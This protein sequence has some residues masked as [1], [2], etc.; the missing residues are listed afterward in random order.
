VAV[1]VSVLA[2]GLASAQEKM[3]AQ[4]DF[5]PHGMHAGLHLAVVK[6]WF[7][8]AGLEVEVLDGKGSTSTIQQVA[9]G[10]IDVGFAQL[11]AMAGAVSNGLPVMS[12]M[13]LIRAGDN[14]VL[15]PR[16]TGWKTVADLKGKRIAV[17]AGSATAFFVDAFFEAAKVPR[18]E[19]TIVNV[20]SSAMVST[21]TVKGVDAV[22]STVAFF[23]P[24]VEETRPSAGIYFSDVGLRIPGYGLLVRSEMVEKRADALT[25]FVAV[26]Q[27]TWNYIFAGHEEEAVD[28]ILQQRASMR[29]DK[30]VLLGQLKAY[31][32]LFNTP[33]TQGKPIGW[34]SEKD[35][36]SAIES[37]QK[38]NV[39]KPGMKPDSFFTNRFVPGT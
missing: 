31:M 10:Q 29:L 17:P 19:V 35:W 8:E 2:I 6:G 23:Q 26:Q 39:V 1:A 33:D 28:A 20:D 36:T 18:S 7:K 32:P 21:Y 3:T 38:V 5:S 13:G 4:T 27:R 25:K 22:M 14:G 37:M 15:F 12:I 9:A 11:A 16:E 24:I 34:Q 30:K